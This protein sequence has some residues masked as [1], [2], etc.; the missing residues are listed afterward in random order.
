MFRRQIT[1]QFSEATAVVDQQGR[2]ERIGV[3]ELVPDKTEPVQLQPSRRVEFKWPMAGQQV[4]V[5]ELLEQQRAIGLR[6]LLGQSRA[7]VTDTLNEID[8]KR[9]LTALSR[10]N[11]LNVFL[12][13]G[14][15]R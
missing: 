11:A 5:L 7:R 3:E 9:V 12:Q 10:I 1:A 15:D 14:L 2:I 8:R 4:D 13:F 6:E